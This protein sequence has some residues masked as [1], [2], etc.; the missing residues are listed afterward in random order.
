MNDELKE[1]MVYQYKD[2]GGDYFRIDKILNDVDLVEIMVVNP[3]TLVDDFRILSDLDFILELLE[4][5]AEPVVTICLNCKEYHWP[6]HKK[7]SCGHGTYGTTH[8]NNYVH[9]K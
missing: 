5:K 4:Y 9:I 7:C 2:P 8:S 6:T 3:K 1:G